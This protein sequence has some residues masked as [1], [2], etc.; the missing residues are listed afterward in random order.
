MVDR[1]IAS[2]RGGESVSGLLEV[3]RRGVLTLTMSTYSKASRR[4][5]GSSFCEGFGDVAFVPTD[6]DAF[7]GEGPDKVVVFD[8][9]TAQVGVPKNSSCCCRR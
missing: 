3:W 7:V 6:T 1:N 4:A 2:T 9:E 5:V 8:L